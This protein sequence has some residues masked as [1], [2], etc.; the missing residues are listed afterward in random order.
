MN[1]T[2][3]NHREQ[4]ITLESILDRDNLNAAYL[5]VVR[6]KG[7]AGVDGMP[8]DELLA[9]LKTHGQ[10]LV[11]SLRD[12][13]YRP[14][15]VRRVL[16]PKE[17]KGEFRPLGIPTVLDRF[18]QQA[19]AQVLSERYD[20]TFSP[21]SHGFRPGRSC[22]T[23]IEQACR[24]AN[25]GYTWI[26]DLDLAKFFDT[27]NHAK[28]L[29]ILSN[30]CE[31]RVVS[32]I[33][34]MLRAPAD[35]NGKRTP[36]TMGTPQG[37]CVSPVLANILLNELDSELM[38]RGLRFV[39]YADDMMIFCRSEKAARRVFEHIRPFIEKKL[40]LRINVQKSKIVHICSKDLKFLG[41]GFYSKKQSEEKTEVLPVPHEK[42]KVKCKERLRALTQR[43]CGRSVEVVKRDLGQFIRGWVGY[44]RIGKMKGFVTETDRWLRRRIRQLYWKQWKRIHK[45]YSM[46]RE[47]GVKPQKAWEW[48]NTRKCYWRVAGSP[49]IET[50]L[51]NTRLRNMGWLTLTELYEGKP[52]RAMDNRPVRVRTL[53]GVGG[54]RGNPPPT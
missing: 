14:Q 16:I 9:Y 27:V 1:H 35:G 19:T 10:A 49:V 37:G 46:L 38:R 6:N 47:Y 12:G 34:R 32:L 41:F 52:A 3:I 53:G 8:V 51:T 43:N 13:S 28:L 29:Q 26:V 20:R 7:A 21:Y 2:P 39:R 54:R 17:G 24:F 42:A 33:H 5:Q 18:V 44:F 31:G 30:R 15:P 11:T 23:A 36:C 48:A 22:H 50:A 45:R 40:F 4:V 25:D